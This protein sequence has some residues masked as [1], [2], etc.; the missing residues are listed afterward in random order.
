MLSQGK[1]TGDIRPLDII[2]LLAR[3]YPQVEFPQ[4][5]LSFV[6]RQESIGHQI[7]RA[8]NGQPL[9]SFLE[10]LGVSSSSVSGFL[11]P[12]SKVVLKASFPHLLRSSPA[13][14]DSYFAD[15]F[16]HIFALQEVV[17]D[18]ETM[19]GFNRHGKEHLK[20]VTRRMLTLLRRVDL[21]SPECSRT[22]NEAIVA[23]YL[24]DIGNLISRKDHGLYGIYLLTQLFTDIA[25]DQETLSSFLRVLEAV[26]FHEVEFG[27]HLSSLD[28]LRL[29][30]LSLI[31]ADKTDVSFRRVSTKSNVPAA[32][33]D[34]YT[35]VNLLTADS[36]IKCQKNSFQWEIHFSPKVGHD[37][38]ILFPELLKRA[39]RVWV[40]KDWQTLYR[41]DNIEYVFIFSATFLRL[42]L[43]RLLFTIRAVFAF[44]PSIESFRLVIKDDERGVSLN[45]IFTRRD[46]QEKIGLIG[47]NLF[48]DK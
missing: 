13:E 21:Q 41:Q 30:T 31:V 16:S 43:P 18:S 19:T 33:S 12:N 24:H 2:D 14:L 23:G 26:L 4:G 7:R 17:L 32:I 3:R 38:A 15:R 46:Y 22:E 11:D 8:N 45:R 5:F 10:D 1:T 29:A 25:R 28:D 9:V 37:Q 36:R 6:E 48:K 47:K 20:T 34:A 39:E 44:S 35:L 40:P 27:S 42:Y